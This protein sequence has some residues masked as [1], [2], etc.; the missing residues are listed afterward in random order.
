VTARFQDGKYLAIVGSILTALVVVPYVG[1]LLSAVG[2]FL[3]LK[4]MKTFSCYYQDNGIY[5]N[6]VTSAKY[7]AVTLTALG[8]VFVIITIT[9]P[10]AA[11]NRE[12]SLVCTTMGIAAF[13]FSIFAAYHIRKTFNLFAQK[14]G[15]KTF[16]VAGNL[17]LAGS[18]AVVLQV[19]FLVVLIAWAL[20]VAC[21]INIL[22]RNNM[23]PS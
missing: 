23:L 4:A 9:S 10:L 5:Q 22:P 3:L 20:A 17:L 14:T 13:M 8:V 7:Y 16:M 15:A 12:V 21:F 19:G 11:V 18:V 1:L 2:L 6:S